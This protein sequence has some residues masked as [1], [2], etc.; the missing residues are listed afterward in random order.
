MFQILGVEAQEKVPK[1]FLVQSPSIANPP[2]FLL[3]L[4]KFVRN[5]EVNS[6]SEIEF[7]IFTHQ[8]YL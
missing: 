2:M 7:Q 4:E 3:V 5:S 1:E 8:W 6:S